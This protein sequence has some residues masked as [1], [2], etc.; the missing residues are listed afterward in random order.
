[1]FK[2]ATFN[3]TVWYVLTL[4]VIS[5]LFSVVIYQFAESEVGHR[6]DSIHVGLENLPSFVL[7]PSNNAYEDLRDAQVHQASINLILAL[8]YANF[9]VLILGGF[10]G[11]LLARRTLAPIEEAHNAQS[12]FVSD[13]SHELRTP[14]AVMKTELEVAL[15]E[16]K[17]PKREMRE[18]LESNLEEVDKLTRLSQTLLSLSRLD[19]EKLKHERINLNKLAHQVAARY[20]KTGKRIKVTDLGRPLIVDAHPPSIEE[21]FIVLIDNALK[22]SPEN[23]LVSIRLSHRVG[24]ACFEITN[25]GNGI[26]LRDLPHIFD[27]FY[28]ADNA[29]TQNGKS[30]FGLGLSLAKTIVQIHNGELSVTSAPGKATTFTVLLPTIRNNQAKTQ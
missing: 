30:S 28:R 8:V 29:R 21:L 10:G 14:L 25:T 17:L 5:I 6:I 18:L 12:R 26:S 22:Y 23:S 15:R 3:L 20:D 11:Y 13:A 19:Y 4:M 16:A 7:P 27:R 1:M 24:K 2:S 9:V